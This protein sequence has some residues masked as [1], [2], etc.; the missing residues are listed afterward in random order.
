ME[1]PENQEQVQAKPP[2]IAEKE[3][4]KMSNKQMIGIAVGVLALV[5]FVAFVAQN[6]NRVGVE[7]LFWRFQIRI[8]FLI[9]ISAVLGGAMTFSFMVYRR[10]KKKNKR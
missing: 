9:V 6:W 8:I 5:F 10:R 2:V 3:V 1:T 4:K 7:F